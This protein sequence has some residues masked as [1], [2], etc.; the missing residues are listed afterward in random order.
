MRMLTILILL[1]LAVNLLSTSFIIYRS[2]SIQQATAGATA[3]DGRV[4]F[5]INRPPVMAVP[6]NGSLTQ[7]IPYSCQLNAT[8]PDGQALTYTQVAQAPDTEPVLNLTSDG[9]L[10]GTPTN[11]QTG[12]HSVLLIVNDGS[13]CDNAYA[14]SLFNFS[15][16]NVN[17]PPYLVEDIPNRAFPTDT[18]LFAFF[19]DDYFADP[20]GD[21]L[22]YAY[23]SGLAET[24]VNITLLPTSQVVF[25]SS[26]CGDAYFRFTATDPGNLSAESNVVTVTVRCEDDEEE[27]EDADESGDSSGSGGG[28]GLCLPELICLPWSDC[29]PTG[30]QIQVCRDKYGCQGDEEIKFYRNCTYEEA[31]PEC[32]EDWLC[33]EWSVC[34]IDGFQNRTC[35][36]LS[37]CGTQLTMPP[38]EQECVYLPTCFDGV[39]NGNETG[40]D[41]GGPCGPC[42][43][44]QEPGLLEDGGRLPVLAFLAIIIIL[45]ALLALLILYRE[46]VYEGMAELG[47]LLARRRKKALLLTPSE[48]QALLEQLAAIEPGKGAYEVLATTVRTFYS[49]AF[50]LPFEYTHE[51]LGIAM[52]AKDLDADTL[53]TL[54]DFH[55]RLDLLES[56]LEG[57]NELLLVSIREEQRLLVCMHSAYAVEEIARELEERP[58]TEE[59]GFAE[60][61]RLRLLNAYEALQF[62][63]LEQAQREYLHILRAYEEVDERRRALLYPDIRRLYLEIKYVGETMDG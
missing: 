51:E 20:D 16:A 19:L 17:D 30:Q 58:I 22:T 52:G 8:D 28:G 21:D 50:D 3:D 62:R 60:E 33:T 42:V 23:L 53:E 13:G 14:F 49:M 9:L 55:G 46:K 56:G 45:A 41:C 6:C 32:E 10:N 5:C 35:E 48:K 29:Y 39:R 24:Q 18:E 38:L 59:V 36:D 2:E 37:G 25:E 40:V 43:Q 54:R 1:L 15:V 4:D 34:R 63:L 26:G 31:P 12:N 7:D 61:V 47:W 44:V 57:M 11:D 27:E